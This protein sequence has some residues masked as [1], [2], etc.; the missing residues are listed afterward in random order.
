MLK[1]DGEEET[2]TN[3]HGI[4]RTS[5]QI[6]TIHNAEVKG[7]SSICLS[8]SR[9]AQ[10]VNLRN[11]NPNIDRKSCPQAGARSIIPN[12]I[13]ITWKLHVWKT[14]NIPPER[15]PT[16][17]I[18]QQPMHLDCGNNKKYNNT[19]AKCKEISGQISGENII[20]HKRRRAAGFALVNYT[21]ANA[22]DV[23]GGNPIDPETPPEP[24]KLS[25]SL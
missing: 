22:L 8:I 2:D 21:F 18:L 25:S 20:Q 23:S 12:F 13:P 19:A 17:P 14:L 5:K 9:G 3:S 16:Q 10:I 24:R 7:T 15:K 6:S 4:T 1:D 11:D